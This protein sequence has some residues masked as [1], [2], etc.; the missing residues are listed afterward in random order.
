MPAIKTNEKN[1]G[2]DMKHFNTVIFDLDGTLLNTLTDL[3]LSVNKALAEGGFPAR[4]ESEVRSALGNGYHYLME[5]CAPAGT[6]EHKIKEILAVFED[7]YYRHSMDNTRPYDGIPET[8]DLLNAKGF[9]MAIV[10]N[11]GMKAVKELARHFFG[12]SIGIA[13]GESEKVRRKPAP[14]S[15]AE[16]MSLLG[17]TKE[18][19]LYV[20]D[21]E[22]DIA[23]AKNAGIDCL[24]VSWGFRTREQLIASGATDIIDRPSQIAAFLGL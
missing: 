1:T 21:S 2:K 17:S 15:V 12:D 8:I 11:K 16:A 24:S 23:T 10:S 22:V 9:K 13:I 19:T 4:T 3:H 20:G 6:E 5:H 14:D 18:E 7:Y